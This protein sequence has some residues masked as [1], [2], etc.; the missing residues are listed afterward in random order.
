[1]SN[2]DFMFDRCDE[3]EKAYVLYLLGEADADIESQIKAHLSSCPSCT[4]RARDLKDEVRDLDSRLKEKA[5]VTWVK[6]RIISGL[7][8]MPSHVERHKAIPISW[9]AAAAM[10][11]IAVSL[12]FFIDR[13]NR[14]F[15]YTFADGS[16]SVKAVAGSIVYPVSENTFR[17]E[18]GSVKV[19]LE[20]AKGLKKVSIQT[21]AVDVDVQSAESDGVVDFRV[22]FD[23]SATVEVFKGILQIQ[24]PLV[25]MSRLVLLA[26]DVVVLSKERKER[27]EKAF[28]NLKSEDYNVC[29]SA[30]RELVQLKSDVEVRPL[31]KSEEERVREIS[32]VIV[33]TL[34]FGRHYLFMHA[35]YE[36]EPD[37]VELLAQSGRDMWAGLI[38]RKLRDKEDL[39]TRDQKR[40]L[41]KDLLKE[42]GVAEKLEDIQHGRQPVVED[43][44]W[45]YLLA[46]EYGDTRIR[47]AVVWA[48]WRVRSSLTEK[49]HEELV[50]AMFKNIEDEKNGLDRSTFAFILKDS[51]ARM[52]ADLVKEAIQALQKRLNDQNHRTRSMSA[53]ALGRVS[54]RLDKELFEMVIK[55]ILIGLNHTDNAVRGIASDDIGQKQIVERLKGKLLSETIEAVE[56]ALKAEKIPDIIGK[57]KHAITGLNRQK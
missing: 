47:A 20:S 18:K 44:A 2:P 53:S 50:R 32:N 43:E 38:G 1:M 31:L 29:A 52:D 39:F 37:F 49:L 33:K 28:K 34:E 41:G 14:P 15:E 57:L 9:F 4:A 26:S 35:I 10:I 11:L 27:I 55:V 46:L 56:S 19:Y 8:K 24:G 21:D 36:Q 42:K 48:L 51:F 54:D 13:D 5:D 23:S 40:I 7:E 3:V 6:R 45:F 25:P 16:G 22:T 17:L 12:F 30:K